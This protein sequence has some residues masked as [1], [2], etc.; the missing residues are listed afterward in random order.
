MFSFESQGLQPMVKTNSQL[1]VVFQVWLQLKL[2]WK[3]RSE[4]EREFNLYGFVPATFSPPVT[5][6]NPAISSAVR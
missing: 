2:I 5:S 1:E 4:Y 6:P 3:K